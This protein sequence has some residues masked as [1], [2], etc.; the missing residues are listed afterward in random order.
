MNEPDSQNLCRL[1][2]GD[3]IRCGNC[4]LSR[5]SQQETLELKTPQG[6]QRLDVFVPQGDYFGKETM[7][8]HAVLLVQHGRPILKNLRA[9]HISKRDLQEALRLHGI[10]D[11]GSVD[12]AYK[13]RNGDISIVKKH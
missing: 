13:E 11:I 5:D 12:E 2:I 8:G 6:L 3:R 4:S 7:K 9:R 1:A 10:N